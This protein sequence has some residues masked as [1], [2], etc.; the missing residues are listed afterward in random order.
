MLGEVAISDAETEELLAIYDDTTTLYH[1]AKAGLDR[2]QIIVDWAARITDFLGKHPQSPYFPGASLQLAAYH[3]RLMN[4]TGVRQHAEAAWIATRDRSEPAATQIARESAFLLANA[5]ILR[6]DMAAY[7]ELHAKELVLSPRATEDRWSVLQEQRNLDV[8]DPG[9]S[10][11]CGPIA[12]S[13]MA[14][15]V[16]GSQRSINSLMAHR[17]GPEGVDLATL[18]RVGREAGLAVRAVRLASLEAFPVPSIVHAP[19]A[20]GA[21]GRGGDEYSAPVGT[22]TSK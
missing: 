12:L 11:N 10:A 3:E 22:P 4:W 19:A 7:D 8:R 1:A 2:R 6:G 15:I 20:S 21:Q 17:S 9:A 18:G 5:L 14:R 16:E 13:Q